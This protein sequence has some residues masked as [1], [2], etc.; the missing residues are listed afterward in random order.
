MNHLKT[1]AA[2]VIATLCATAASAEGCTIGISMK[3][4]D[5]PYFAA[6]DVAARKRAEEIGC[7][8]IS[9]DAGNDLNKQVADVEDLVAQGVDALI[10]NVRDSQG[11]VRA[12]NAAAD[13]GVPVIAIDSSIDA[14]ANI[15]TLVQSSNTRNGMLVGQWLADETDGQDLKIALLSGDQGN[16]V[17]QERRLGVLA[18]LIEGQLK[19]GGKASYEIVGQGWGGW[20][21]EGGLTAMEDILTA[22]PDV[23]V[24]LG[25]NDSMLLGARNALRAQ[26]LE[27]KVLLVAAA[28]GQKEA[29]ELIKTGEYG[30]TGLNNPAQVA[31][32]AVDIAKGVIDGTM[33][34][35]PKITYTEPAVITQQNV[36]QYYNP[37]AVF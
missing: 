25:E 1:T 33:T 7:T 37:E 3:T 27:D 11:L 26:G 5:A 17:G 12:V 8:P 35:I 14:S 20:G 32:T 31:A 24:V 29:L 9:A 15:V 10:I 30:A 16:E 28:D 22:H 36:D 6:Q 4:L 13:A 2:A 19:N 18:G 21:N 34:D 23:N